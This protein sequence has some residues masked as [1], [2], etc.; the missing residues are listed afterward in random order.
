MHVPNWHK[1]DAVQ[2]EII[3]KAIG[4]KEAA[5]IWPY[6]IFH[7]VPAIMQFDN[8]F[9]IL[10]GK[11]KVH[12][13]ADGEIHN[14]VGPAVE[15]ADGKKF[16]Y[17]DEHYLAS[18]SAEKIVMSP[19]TLTKD[20]ILAIQNEEERRVAIDRM[21]WSKYLT[22]IDAK[23]ADSRENW[24]D[25]TYEVLIDPPTEEPAESWRRRN[26]PLRMVLSCRS[27][28]RK[29]FIAVPRARDLNIDG[30]E[31]KIKNC[32]DAQ[33]WLSDGATTKYLDY[34]KY[35]MNVIGAS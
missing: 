30:T 15:W 6:E 12:F 29:Y 3:S 4:C 21:G 5:T 18:E 20:E 7:H 26:E 34:A 9:L 27:T 23:I 22:A 32:A 31:N 14:D 16:W 33:M 24:V 11:P 13:N 19:E 17:I 8:A 28:G 1:Y 35:S 10:A 25:N 2:A